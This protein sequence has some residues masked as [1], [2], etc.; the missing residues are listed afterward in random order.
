M[1]WQAPMSGESVCRSAAAGQDVL[2]GAQAPRTGPLRCLELAAADLG[3]ATLALIETSD[4]YM[5]GLFA[6]RHETSLRSAVSKVEF[7]ASIFLS[8][9]FPSVFMAAFPKTCG[10]D[11]DVTG[12]ALVAISLVFRRGLEITAS[13]SYRAQLSARRARRARPISRVRC[14]PRSSFGSCR[15]F[16]GR[17][18]R[19]A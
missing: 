16:A 8:R 4:L 11:S 6:T 3:T 12:S 14:A 10:L 2:P 15:A 9:V 19:S 13:S 7:L 18:L 5:L 1:S 17:V